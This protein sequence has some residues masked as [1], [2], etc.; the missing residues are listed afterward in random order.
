MPSN[1]DQ[2]EARWQS[3]AA[4]FDAQASKALAAV[5]PMDPL[6][7]ER[8]SQHKSRFFFKDYRLQLIG[9]FKGKRILDVGCG[10]GVNSI[11][12]AKLGAQV[13]GIDISPG[14]IA[15]AR[16]K[17]QV[18]GIENSCSFVCAPLETAN[19][20]PGSFDVIWGDAVLHHI[21]AD[22]PLVMRKLCEYAKPG[23]LMIF[24]EPVN[25][26]QTL[27]RIRFMVPLE[28]DA[29]P[30]ERPLEPAEI[31]IV[32]QYLPDLKLSHFT[33]LGRL[34]RFLLVNWNYERA[35][36]IRRA[37]VKGLAVADGGLLSIPGIR[38]LAGNAVLYG[39]R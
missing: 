24:G 28:T 13:T 38:Q 15:V 17:A 11:L 19:F 31:A 8:Y 22:L 1:S 16:K 21:I 26:N 23:A 7:F 12:L 18:N 27:R 25:F 14:A 5:A 29:T 4:F 10:D 30:D 39:H 9:D 20:A 32:R 3:E 37:L 33:L 35:S 2:R 6:T 36:W 34:N